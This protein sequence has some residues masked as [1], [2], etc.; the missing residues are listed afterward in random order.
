MI[1]III[2]DITKSTIAKNLNLEKNCSI[3]LKNKRAKLTANN[4]NIEEAGV[5]FC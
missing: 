5:N 1:V 4:L 3:G 2:Q